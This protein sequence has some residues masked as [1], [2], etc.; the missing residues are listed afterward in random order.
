VRLRFRTIPAIEFFLLLHDDVPA[1]VFLYFPEVDV[2]PLLH[3]LLL[4]LDLANL[5]WNGLLDLE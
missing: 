2:L 5:D 1:F 3:H 4:L